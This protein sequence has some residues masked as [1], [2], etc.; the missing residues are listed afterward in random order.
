MRRAVIP[1]DQVFAAQWASG[2]SCAEIGRAYGCSGET[3]SA[4]AARYNLPP[5]R[6]RGTVAQGHT[7]RLVVDGRQ[8]EPVKPIGRAV[9]SHDFW[10]EDRDELVRE[11]GGRYGEINALADRWGFTANTV[12]ARWHRLRRAA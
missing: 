10:T 1:N 8:I 5:R 12:L 6:E 4:A 3:V 11:T 2:L 7:A 9:P